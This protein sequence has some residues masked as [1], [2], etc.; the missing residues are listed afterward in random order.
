MTPESEKG[1]RRQSRHSPVWLSIDPWHSFYQWLRQCIMKKSDEGHGHHGDTR[2]TSLKHCH[3][4]YSSAFISLHAQKIPAHQALSPA[5]IPLITW[6]SV[7]LSCT[8][9]A[10]SPPL[11]VVVSAFW[12]AWRNKLQVRFCHFRLL[13]LQILPVRASV[14]AHTSARSGVGDDGPVSTETHEKEPKLSEKDHYKLLSSQL[15]KPNESKQNPPT[16]WHR[17]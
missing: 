3:F 6:A 14:C 13:A 5:H 12:D 8:I 1:R 9:H 4:L 2:E 17:N 16:K 11:W 7:S 10:Y 15:K